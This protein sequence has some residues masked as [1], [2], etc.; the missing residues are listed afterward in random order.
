M[1]AETDWSW[2]TVR[3]VF[4]S[5]PLFRTKND[6]RLAHEELSNILQVKNTLRQFRYMYLNFV[7]SFLPKV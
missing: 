1:V 4:L 5:G 2:A 6:Q 7:I 3:E